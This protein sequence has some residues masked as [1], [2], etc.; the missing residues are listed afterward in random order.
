MRGMNT[1][2]AYCFRAKGANRATGCVFS[3]WDSPGHA[4]EVLCSHYNESLQCDLH[5]WWPLEFL[6][7]SLPIPNPGAYSEF[8]PVF[9][10]GQLHAVILLRRE[11]RADAD[12]AAR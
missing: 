12:E 11:S 1:T 9:A 5:N 3:S 7:F 10:A 4:L 8:C 6:P 2:F